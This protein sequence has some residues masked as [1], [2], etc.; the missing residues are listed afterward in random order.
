[1]RGAIKRFRNPNEEWEKAQDYTGK[2]QRGHRVGNEQSTKPSG[3]RRDRAGKAMT[4]NIGTRGWSTD[5]SDSV[6]MK[7]HYH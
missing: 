4:E 1:M 2:V 5:S 7:N 3:V 6:G